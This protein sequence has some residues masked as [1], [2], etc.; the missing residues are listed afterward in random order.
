MEFDKFQKKIDGLTSSSDFKK[1]IRLLKNDVNVFDILRIS[2]VEIRH[3][4]MLAWLLDANKNH[5]FHDF[6][7]KSFFNEISD[8]SGKNLDFKSFIVLREWK[9]I[10]L[11]LI[12]EK[13]QTLICVENKYHSGEHDNQLKRYQKTLEEQYPKFQKYYVYLTID[14]SPASEENWVS[15]SYEKIIGFIKEAMKVYELYPKSEIII[16]QYL[17]VLER[18]TMGDNQE[19]KDLCDKIYGEYGEAI[20]RI[21]ENS[22]E[23]PGMKMRKTIKEWVTKNLPKNYALDPDRT[24]NAYIRMKSNY[25]NQVLP[26][27]VDGKEGVWGNSSPYYYEI[28][29]WDDG[30]FKIYMTVSIKGASAKILE[31]EQLIHALG[32][33]NR[34]RK[35]NPEKNSAMTKSFGVFRYNSESDDED[36]LKFVETVLTRSIPAFEQKVA[37]KL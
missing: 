1:L 37:E 14:G 23:D 31:K 8:E 22:R 32:H 17:S 18:S 27:F 20:D 3:S 5:G 29:I 36:A 21:V 26:N 25:M 28:N 35:F 9:N 24:R 33:D 6:I 7:L 4:N 13:E 11:L 30:S 19:V 16:K 2:D 10:D 34:G 15:L 12:S